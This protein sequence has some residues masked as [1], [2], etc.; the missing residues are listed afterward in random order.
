MIKL[1]LFKG[2]F[3]ILYKT[4]RF[5]DFDKRVVFIIESLRLFVVQITFLAKIKVIAYDTL[6]PN[7]LYGKCKAFVALCVMLDLA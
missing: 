1:F 3:D 7:V 5:A 2:N 4:D 6:V